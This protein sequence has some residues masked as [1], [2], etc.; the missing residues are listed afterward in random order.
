MDAVCPLYWP[1]ARYHIVQPLP[2]AGETI[3]LLRVEAADEQ[4]A[5]AKIYRWIRLK[6]EVLQ[7]ISAVAPYIQQLLGQG[8]VELEDLVVCPASF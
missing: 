1:D 2:T 7:R 3:D 6:N 4:R 8:Q 5:V